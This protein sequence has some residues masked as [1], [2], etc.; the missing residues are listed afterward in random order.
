MIPGWSRNWFRT[1]TARPGAAARPTARIASEQNR[2]GTA[3]PISRPTSTSGSVDADALEHEA[4][5]LRSAS[6]NEPNSEVA[7]RTAVAIAMPFV[8]ALVELPDRVEPAEDLGG[9]ALELA[10]HL[11][12]ALRVVRD[13]A[14][15][16]HRHDDAHRG[17]HPHAGE[18]D[19]VQPLGRCVP[20]R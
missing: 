13:R 11:R 4:R 1:S 12:D 17:E 9:P 8:M 5:R 2:N 7:A 6:S 3:P 19:E 14:V 16:V 10:R 20:P 15:G 18:R